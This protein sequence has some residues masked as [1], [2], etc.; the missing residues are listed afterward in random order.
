MALTQLE[1]NLNPK[2]VMLGLIFQQI[3]LEFKLYEAS[4]FCLK[5]E[6]NFDSMSLKQ[7]CCSCK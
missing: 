5:F 7:L 6:G 3:M 4:L 2:S 1:P